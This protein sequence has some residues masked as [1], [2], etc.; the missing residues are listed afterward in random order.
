MKEWLQGFFYF[1]KSQLRAVF[2]LAVLIAATV[3]APQ[4]YLQFYPPE[5]KLNQSFHYAIEKFKADTL[6]DE[7]LSN[8][9][10][11]PFEDNVETHQTKRAVKLFIFN[12][13]EI[14]QE[15]WMQLGFSEKQAEV[16]ERI[17]A[18]GF[19]F[20]TAEDLKKVKI[21]GEAGYERLKKFVL[22]PP[23]VYESKKSD[24]HTNNVNPTS[25]EMVLLDLNTADSIAIRKLAGYY[26]GSKIVRFRNALGGF[27]SVNQVAETN[28]LPDSV[29][30]KIKSKIIVSESAVRKVKCNSYPADSLAKHPYI[31]FKQAKIIVRYRN[32]H[33][34]FKSIETIQ[35]AG[36]FSD[37][38]F[39]K[40]SPY[41]GL[42]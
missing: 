12:P 18:R 11:I 13:N 39:E 3:I 26:Y 28:N 38:S 10:V 27:I 41:L 9:D 25:S 6:Q 14:G 21:I 2:L 1:T 35:Q 4:L 37:S 7:M 42:D 24:E 34:N 8:S 15:E 22:I 40:L 33:G 32:T 29:F 16:I 5:F 30:Q 31:N 36:I 17:K 20:R 19:K 23:P